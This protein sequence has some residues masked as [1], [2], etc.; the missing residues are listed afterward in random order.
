[1]RGLA[2]G[3]KTFELRVHGP[4]LSQH[5]EV[6]EPPEGKRYRLLCTSCRGLNRPPIVVAD[7]ELHDLYFAA[8]GSIYEVRV[9]LSLSTGSI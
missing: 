8:E 7:S 5:V 6:L 9:D 4:H 2:R 1:M 3:T